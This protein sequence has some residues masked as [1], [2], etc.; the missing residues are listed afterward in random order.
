[1]AWLIFDRFFR[2]GIGL[3]MTAL[4]ARYLGP[5]S[6]GRYNYAQAFVVILGLLATLGLDRIVIRDFIKDINKRSEILG[7]T[8]WLKIG[9]A[10][11]AYLMA[12]LS[13]LFIKSDRSLI[14]ILINIMSVSF[15]FQAFDTIDFWFQSQMNSKFVVIART[16][17]II[18]ITI[19]NIFLIFL[20]SNLIYFA[21]TY[22]L[23]FAIC[24]VFFY[25]ISCLKGLVIQVWSFNF[26]RAKQMLIDSWPLLVA[27]LSASI[28]T[29]ID[30][31]MIGNMLDEYQVGIYAASTRIFELFIPIIF[32]INSSVYPKLVKLYDYPDKTEFYRAYEWITDVVTFLSMGMFV[33]VFFFGKYIIYILYGN[34]FIEATPIFILQIYSIVIIFN[35]CLRISYIT[36]SNNQHIILITTVT[37]AVLNII[38]NYYFIPIFG[39]IGAAI[40]MLITRIFSLLFS[41]IF[42]KSTRHIFIIQLRSL[43]FFSLAKR[44]RTYLSK[45]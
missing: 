14:F 3:L 15:F 25:V 44:I 35:S 43:F 45:E 2:R 26:N 34:D 39:V 16:A 20:K 37:A 38:I 13:V 23:E 7:T 30:Q 21:V 40:A 28:Y 12:M 22:S 29:R 17:A 41:N 33:F 24:A 32:I 8:F 9:G 31:I 27:A 5:N 6:F 10:L 1:M 11:I 4:L 19:I 36:I 42:F 18:I